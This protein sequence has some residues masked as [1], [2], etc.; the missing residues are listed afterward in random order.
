MANTSQVTFR[1][2]EAVKK[3]A[4]SKARASG[5][6]LQA[7]LNSCLRGYLNDEIKVQ[8]TAVV[9]KKRELKMYP[10]DMKI[11]QKRKKE[12][13]EGRNFVDAFESIRRLKEK[14]NIV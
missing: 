11:Y 7:I 1:A 6:T 2:E 5:V 12:Y 3:A 4:L 10:D 14:H 9:V 8:T 13:D